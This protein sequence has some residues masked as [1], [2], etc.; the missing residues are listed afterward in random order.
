V[1][2]PACRGV[3]VVAEHKR[4]EVDYCTKCSGVWFDAGELELLLES[5]TLDETGLTMAEIMA[6]PA[7]K[8]AEKARLCPICRRKMRKVAI[9]SEPEVLIDVCLRGDGIWFDGGELSQVIGQLRGTG[10][11]ATGKQ[12]R[13][14]TFLGEVFQAK[15]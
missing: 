2:C 11:T 13:V 9:G 12:G 8:V 3:M 4:I 5:M 7:K 1:D 6:L 14:I 15:R 10:S